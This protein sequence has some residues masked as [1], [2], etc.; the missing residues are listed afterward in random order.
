MTG[1]TVIITE[2]FISVQVKDFT[3]KYQL[4][5]RVLLIHTVRFGNLNICSFSL[6]TKP[7]TG[8]LLNVISF[9]NIVTRT[10]EGGG[11]GSINFFTGPP[12]PMVEE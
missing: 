8:I 11:G 5:S 3:V 6:P 4:S 9:R 12:C 1:V 7:I 2:Q 10:Q